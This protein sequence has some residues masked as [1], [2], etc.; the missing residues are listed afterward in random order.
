MPLSTTALSFIE[1]LTIFA[2]FG[3]APH[4]PFGRVLVVDAAELAADD[5]ELCITACRGVDGAAPAL[6]RCEPLAATQ[7][8]GL[9]SAVEAIYGVHLSVRSSEREVHA[10]LVGSIAADGPTDVP[11]QL[12]AACD[13]VRCAANETCVQGRCEPIRDADGALLS[14]RDARRLLFCDDGLTNPSADAPF[15]RTFPGPRLHPREQLSGYCS[16]SQNVS[17]PPGAQQIFIDCNA[18]PGSGPCGT[19]ENPCDS[20]GS[21]LAQL[22]MGNG[23]EVLCVS[24]RCTPSAPIRLERRHDNPANVPG[25]G[26]VSLRRDPLTMLG[27]DRDGDGLYP[28]YDT[29]DVAVISGTDLRESV[30]FELIG[31]AVPDGEQREADDE[32]IVGLEIS[33]LR[34]D[35]LPAIGGEPC[36]LLRLLHGGRAHLHDLEIVGVCGGVSTDPV[37]GIVHL[38]NAHNVWLDRLSCEDCGRLVR[39]EVG[40]MDNRNF[41]VSRVTYI[42]NP[43]NRASDTNVFNAIYCESLHGVTPDLMTQNLD[44][45]DSF[46]GLPAPTVGLQRASTRAVALGC[47]TNGGSISNNVFRGWRQSLAIPG[48]SG[49]IRALAANRRLLVSRNFFDYASG[50]PFEDLPT[51][52]RSMISIGEHTSDITIADNYARALPEDPAERLDAFVSIY[53]V[54]GTTRADP[55][56]LEGNVFRGFLARDPLPSVARGWFAALVG[57]NNPNAQDRFEWTWQVDRNVVE[58]TDSA[59]MENIEGVIF[60][61]RFAPDHDGWEAESDTTADFAL[62][63]AANSFDPRGCVHVD[64]PNA[65]ED[66]TFD[67]STLQASPASPR[68]PCAP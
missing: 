45:V 31:E 2:L 55:A 5:M 47:I 10:S 67:Y 49:P 34:I 25:E 22:G 66:L 26:T 29:D 48:P 38:T 30:L 50:Y 57:Q 27:T 62:I 23:R 40:D 58:L 60:D 11:L 63:G 52:L 14:M 6:H 54:S 16:M 33:H 7:R 32:G 4:E 19:A 15:E 18:T 65:G 13:G 51:Q 20:L 44:I 35:E 56:R 59:G 39:M 37:H 17:A 1:S 8:I 61:L 68:V 42:G 36:A 28:P 21:G 53:A 46:I 64:L 43:S 9:T 3:C 12:S 41:R 24:G